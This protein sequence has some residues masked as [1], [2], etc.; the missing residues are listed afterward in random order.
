MKKGLE[1][2][3]EKRIVLAKD[4]NQIVVMSSGYR[5]KDYILSQK[6]DVNLHKATSLYIKHTQGKQIPNSN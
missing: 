1:I 6:G 4:P 2:F 3:K 5:H